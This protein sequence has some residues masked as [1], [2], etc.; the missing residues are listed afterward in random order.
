MPETPGE[1]IAHDNQ[2]LDSGAEGPDE[3][4]RPEHHSIPSGKSGIP[5]THSAESPELKTITAFHKGKN[6]KYK[7]GLLFLCT[8]SELM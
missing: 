6:R 2:S 4:D 1:A 8:S 5:A 3:P 7:W